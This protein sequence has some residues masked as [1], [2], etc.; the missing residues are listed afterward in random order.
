MQLPLADKIEWAVAALLEVSV[1][2]IA[3]R[4][5]LQERQPLL[6]T[7][8]GLL[9]ALEGAMWLTYTLAGVRSRFSLYAY[10]TQQS[11][12]MI[13]RGIAVYEICRVTLARYAGVWRL[14][15]GFLLA[16]LTILA[17]TGIIAAS[18]SGPRYSVII[19]TAGR[20]LELAIVSVLLFGLAFCRY[21]RVEVPGY[22]ALIS[23][24]FGF[25]S[26]VQV[27]NNV[28]LRQYLLSYFPVWRY[29]TLF[30]FDIAT[31]LWG[32]AL[33][34]PLP[35]LRLAPVTLLPGAYE[36]FAPQMTTRLRELNTRLLEM[37]K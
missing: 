19:S 26:A 13:F 27:I 22:L 35:E 21:Y 31:I 34:K 17:F 2:V 33:W 10:W 24:G 4:R 25:Y 37:W 36:E 1:F 18:R 6:T 5:E 14:C 32:V 30:S 20:G 23:V 7:Y 16:I 9:V 11:L 8:L 12:L 15:R 3:L 29:V 28:F